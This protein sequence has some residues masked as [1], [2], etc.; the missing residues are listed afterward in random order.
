M[1]PGNTL[2]RKNSESQTMT[3]KLIKSTVWNLD[4]VNSLVMF[5][6]HKSMDHFDDVFSSD[7]MPDLTS[8][9][10]VFK[11]IQLNKRL[12]DIDVRKRKNK[13]YPAE[14]NPPVPFV[15]MYD[16]CYGD[17]I[18]DLV[19]GLGSQGSNPSKSTN[20][21]GPLLGKMAQGVAD[22]IVSD[23]SELEN[24]GLV[25][26]AAKPGESVGGFQNPISPTPEKPIN[27]IG[28]LARRFVLALKSHPDQVITLRNLRD[29]INDHG[30]DQAP[31]WGKTTKPPYSIS[32]TKPEILDER[33]F[34]NSK[35]KQKSK[36]ELEKRMG[37]AQ[38]PA[39][40]CGPGK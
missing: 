29:I 16:N 28:L 14:G 27:N 5:R 20:I 21:F 35:D 31:S 36:G 23:L 34:Y 15:V 10:D 12:N 7:M 11:T 32:A 19:N 40:C 33:L 22:Q 17:I 3:I 30:L 2:I 25:L 26:Y 1:A 9:E 24:E 8:M 4:V 39:Y 38:S 37:T 13:E 6:M 18:Q